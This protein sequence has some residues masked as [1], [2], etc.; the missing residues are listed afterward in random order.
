MKRIAFAAALIFTALSSSAISQ[1]DRG[2]EI[3][4]LAEITRNLS[5]TTRAGMI[6]QRYHSLYPKKDLNLF[7]KEELRARF[8][9]AN[10]AVFY[11][12]DQ[13][14][15]GEMISLYNTLHAKGAEKPEDLFTVAGAQII[16]R[17]FDR[18]DEI[19]GSESLPKEF[20]I[21]AI[22]DHISN[23]SI[24]WQ[25]LS[26]FP[27]K[28]VRENFPIDKGAYVIIVSNPLCGFSIAA[29]KA[30]QSDGD[31]S[32]FLSKHGLWRVPPARRLYNN[33]AVAWNASHP[34][35]KMVLAYK[36]ESWPII[37][38]WS[39]PIFYFIKNGAVVDKVTGW[40]KNGQN[41][42]QL[43]GAIDRFTQDNKL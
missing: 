2:P 21:P 36:N 13:K 26:P 12:H 41:L 14:I 20:H 4:Q 19:S 39:T 17:N 10:I 22:E 29:S 1:D 27:N 40:P 31:L 24:K 43:H 8:D 7:S 37:D 28:L 35:Q 34:S 3:E 25:I 11:S 9:S 32:N 42:N 5:R 16:S 6:A 33:E 30:I 15:A 18:F 23:E 38:D